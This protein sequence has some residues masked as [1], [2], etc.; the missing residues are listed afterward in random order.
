[1]HYE[2]N[3]VR[4]NRF[5]LSLLQLFK[6][7]IPDVFRDE[8]MNPIGASNTWKWVPYANSYDHDRRQTH[9]VGERRHALGRRHVDQQLRHGALRIALAAAWQVERSPD[10]VGSLRQDGD[11]AEPARSGL[12]LP[13]VAQHHGEVARIADQLVR[14]PG[15]GG[16]VIYI[17]PHTICSW[18]GA[19]VRS[20]GRDSSRLSS[21]LP[22]TEVRGPCSSECLERE[23]YI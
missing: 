17:D 14:G 1:M 18:S 16:N 3:D 23:E 21:P 15:A 2:Y 9:G 6:K 7:P 13:V 20:R 8:V 12:R 11:D 10:R 4:I 22:R 19:G 5:A